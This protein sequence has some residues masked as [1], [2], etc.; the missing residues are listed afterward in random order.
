[1]ILP[2]LILQGVLVSATVLVAIIMS[3]SMLADVADHIEDEDRASA[4]KA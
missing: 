1:M 2:W 3:A 4:W